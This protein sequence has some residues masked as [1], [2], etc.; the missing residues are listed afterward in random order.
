MFKL[1]TLAMLAAPI[2][3]V[4]VA[5]SCDRQPAAVAPGTTPAR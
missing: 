4:L 2:G 3:V 5:S 1:R